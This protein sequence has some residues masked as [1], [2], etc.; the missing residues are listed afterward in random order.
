MTN[1][2]A[3][4]VLDL[5][6]ETAKGICDWTKFIPNKT[7]SEAHKMAVKALEAQE[8]IPVDKKSHPDTP[9]RVQVQLDNGWIITAYYEENE[10]F[11]VPDFGEPI[12]DRWI[13]A[14]KPMPEPYKVENKEV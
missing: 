7:I 13:E 8:W 2:K 9:I 6:V 12:E 1:A 11:S 10:W 5:V 14:W 3:I 4:A